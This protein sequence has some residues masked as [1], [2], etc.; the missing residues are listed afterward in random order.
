MAD[1]EASRP[2]LEGHARS[3]EENHLTPG[4]STR[5]SQRRSFELSSESTP[6]LH[7]RDDIV[8]T[9]GTD[10]G[11]SISPSIV[12]EAGPSD[13][14]P[15]KKSRIRWPTVISL[16][17]LTTAILAILV[18][19][20]AT[21]AVVKEYAQEAAV[22]Q[23]TALSIDSTTPEGVRARIQGNFFMDSARVKS[24]SVRNY[25]RF[26]TWI[27]REIETG[28]SD[29]DVYLPEYGNVLIGNAALPNIKVNIR[30][31]HQ[32]EIDFLTDLTAGDVKGIHGIAMDW[33]EGRLA[34]LRVK[35]KATLHLK[36]GLIALGTQVLADTITF[37][38]YIEND[39]P[40]LPDIN[41]VQ[42][43]VHD[44]DNGTMEVDAS[45]NAMLHSPVALTVPALGFD[46]LVPNCLPGDPYILAASAQTQEI[47]VAP[48]QVT[49]VSVEGIV[50]RL[51]EELTTMCPGGDGSPLDFLVSSYIKGLETT[52]YI[53]G[54]DAPSLSGA[55][56]WM[57]DLLRSVKIPLPFTNK[58]LDNLVKNFS[59]SDTRFSL[60]DP[61]AEPGTPEAQPTVSALVKVLIAIPQEMNLRVDVP[62][63]R[64]LT[65]V[66]YSGQELGKLNLDKWQDANS[67]IVKDVDGASVLLV[68]FAIEEAPLE[69]TDSD[70]LSQLVQDML[71]GSKEIVLHVDA[72]VD[73][74]V[75]TGLGR[76]A[77]RGIPADGDVHVKIVETTDSSLSVLTRVNF[78]NP[79]EYSATIPF[80]DALVLSNNTAL[81]HVTAR[82][83]SLAPGDNTNV[84][85]EFSW[86]PLRNGGLDGIK[87]GQALISSF[88]S[89][90]NTS[91]T[92]QVHQGS[93][94]ALPD[95]GKALSSLRIDVPL[96][97]ISAPGSPDDEDEGRSHFLQDATVHLWSSTAEF[98]LFSPLTST[99]I[100]ITSIHAVAFYKEDEPVGRIDYNEPFD[101]PPGVSQT[102]RLPVNLVLGGGAYDALRRAL[103]QSLA[104]DTVAKVGI[105]IG[106]YENVVVYRGKGIEANIKW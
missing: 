20:F 57:V 83:F 74:K 39:F 98:T 34:R 99:S 49:S 80:A 75:A 36:S 16:V 1:E 82:N 81:A 65:N 54:A 93:I 59:M 87:A 76:F 91:V 89:G 12:S 90:S 31:G 97:T 8:I 66:Y 24:N 100:T 33:I 103:G 61:F 51:P 41:L 42:L 96:P 21:P 23:P 73:A 28:P 53:R 46:I 13:D 72:N 4:S 30:N 64:A 86:D 2:L 94:P 3:S 26:M 88:I 7:R 67:T 52:I 17:G 43:N 101:I 9:Y 35:G 70:I 78:T 47:Q 63:V 22:F 15:S 62:H 71:F 77:V 104:M 25:G 40:A 48:N 50:R 102:P 38:E 19:A 44:G 10:G 32:N 11:P 105:R 55:P 29:V 68:E 14:E 6:L 79:T 18:F 37:E 84:E 5:P 56:E 27:A 60:P 85:V 58:A 69:V 45:V 92:I 95:L 106:D